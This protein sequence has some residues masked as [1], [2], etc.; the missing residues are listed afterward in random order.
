ML[1]RGGGVQKKK[2]NCQKKEKKF[3]LCKTVETS[4]T[5]TIMI[6]LVVSAD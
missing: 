5:E 3:G 1:V 2:S 4:G 6:I